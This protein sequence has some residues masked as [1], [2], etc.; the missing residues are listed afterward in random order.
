MREGITDRIGSGLTDIG[1]TSF[2]SPLSRMASYSTGKMSPNLIPGPGELIRAWYSRQLT[3]SKLWEYLRYHAIDWRNEANTGPEEARIWHDIIELGRPQAGLSEWQRWWRQ[4]QVTTDQLTDRI[5]REG[6]SS[7]PYNRLIMTDYE[8]LDLG[9]VL[10]SL[11]R[12]LIDEDQARQFLFAM[13]F[14]RT[15]DQDLILSLVEGPQLVESLTL[16]NREQITDQQ[17]DTYL[18][19]RGIRGQTERDLL[20]SLRFEIP[21]PSD[22]TRFAVRHVFEPSIAAKFGFADEMPLDYVEWHK[23]QGL[24]QEF[25]I[26]DPVTGEQAVI[27]W[28]MANWWAHWVWPAPT[29]AYSMVQRLRATGG[30]NGGPRDPSGLVFT[31]T[32][33]GY[34]LRGND[35]PPHWRPYLQAISYRVITRGETEQLYKNGTI[36][37][38]EAIEQ[39]QDQGNTKANAELIA[40]GISN[41]VSWE[42]IRALRARQLMKVQSAYQRGILSHD[43]TAVAVWKLTLPNL[44]M[45]NWANQLN[46]DQQLQQALADQ[47]V[48]AMLDTI[49]AQQKQILANQ[50]ITSIKQAFLRLEITYDQ[51][52]Q[53][54]TAA[55]VNAVRAGEYQQ[56]WLLQLQTRGKELSASQ[57]VRFY[58]RG[59]INGAVATA[60]L[61]IVGYS[62]SDA[63]L[64]LADAAVTIQAKSAAQAKQQAKDQNAKIKAQQAIVKAQQAQV[65]QSQ[66]LLAKHSGPAAMKRYLKRGLI[67][68]SLAS[69][70]L[71]I[72][73]WPADDIKRFVDDALHT[74]TEPITTAPQAPQAAPD[75]NIT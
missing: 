28:A 65:K 34:L 69:E 14:T 50:A 6:L 7:R 45:V 30:P 62:L 1:L 19:W 40:T 49:D 54:L 2:F 63:Q 29:Q 52:G 37:K 47:Y 3:D 72:L 43:D 33:L 59:L 51:A 25:T 42:Q 12:G 70:R 58:E 66:A 67:T 31:Q 36:D 74:G 57:V 55:G 24:G 41:E 13:G 64:I 26:T 35:Y 44:A 46:A 10:Q 22:L 17:L 9:T 18:K 61:Q 5:A 48:I 15:T 20:A 73:G 53:L 16:R 11:T 27:N 60:R 56:L 8:N 75:F 39:L 32:D 71:A 38:Q 21:G 68:E 4:N 23:K